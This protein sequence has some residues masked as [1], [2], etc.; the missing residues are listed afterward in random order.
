LAPGDRVVLITLP[1]NHG[2]VVK[3]FSGEQP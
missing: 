1:E 2:P 3:V